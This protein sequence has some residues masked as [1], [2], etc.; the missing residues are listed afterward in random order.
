MKNLVR[1]L[2]VF[3]GNVLEILLENLLEKSQMSKWTTQVK[4]MGGGGGLA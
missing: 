1:F 3:V 4:W 2:V